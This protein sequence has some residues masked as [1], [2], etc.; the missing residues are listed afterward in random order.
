MTDGI[1]A[2]IRHRER[3]GRRRPDVKLLF[4]G[5]DE[6]IGELPAFVRLAHELGARTVVLQA[7]GEYEQVKGRSVALHHR[8]LGRRC[9]DAAREAAGPLGVTIELFPPDHL[10]DGPAAGGTPVPAGRRTKDCFFPWDRAVV[11]TGGDVLPCCAAE[12]AFGNLRA[13]AFADIWRGR[14][15]RRL[16]GALLSGDL[17]L[18]CRT[19]TGQAWRAV[20]AGDPVRAAARLERIRFRQRLRRSRALRR[21]REAVRR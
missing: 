10:S 2:V 9:L 12:T 1:R 14:S 6:T 4:L 17:P 18:M 20:R 13:R 3:A 16:R 5:M 8:P 7:M 21:L 19:C 15:Y 11:T